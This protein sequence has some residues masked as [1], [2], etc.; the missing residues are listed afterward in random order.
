M[1]ATR[2]RQAMTGATLATVVMLVAAGCGGGGSGPS[3]DTSFNETDVRFATMMRPHH[4]QALKT[5]AVE[6]EK[7]SDPRVKALARRI[8]ATQ[9]REIA[10]LEGFLRE[11]GKPEMPAA[12]DQQARWDMNVADERAASGRELD[13]VFL[14]NMIPHHAA[15]V[16][17]AQLEMQ[18]GSSAP[19][20][21]LAMGIK[22]TQ[23]KEIAEMKRLVR[24]LSASG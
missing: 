10:M 17:M 1:L 2:T 24:E 4:E 6:I 9:K 20:K 3:S 21:K 16:P 22:K 11:W 14:T 18:M 19:A 7:G 5:S 13:I 23:L 8:T 15:A 12:A